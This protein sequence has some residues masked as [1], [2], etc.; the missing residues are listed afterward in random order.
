MGFFA[1]TRQGIV[2]RDGDAADVLDIGY[3]DLGAALRYGLTARDLAGAPA[4]TRVPVSGLKFTAPVP[5]PRVLWIAGANY[6]GHNAEIGLKEDPKFPPTIVIASSSVTGPYDDVIAP[7][8]APD[9]VDYECEVAVVIGKTAAGIAKQDAWAHVFGLT[10]AQDISARDVQFGKFLAGM[11]AAKAKSFD[12]F[13]PMGPWLV[14]P[15]EFPDP[16]D[17]GLKTLVDGEVRQDARTSDMLFGVADI[18]S[19]MSGFTTLRPGDVILTGTPAGVAITSKRWVRVGQ[20]IRTEIEVIG[21]LENT[22][23]AA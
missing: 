17:I 21:V 23:V 16:D 9:Q 1:S 20:V 4:K 18:V 6:R 22:L 19:F 15:D 3:P 5:V 11:D 7:A 12:T 8:I 14:T 2:R 10:G 13:T